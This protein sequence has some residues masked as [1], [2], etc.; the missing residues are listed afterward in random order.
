MKKRKGVK[1]KA[2]KMLL[3]LIYAGLIA[4]MNL[5]SAIIVYNKA[6]KIEDSQK[7]IKITLMSI[8]IRFFLFLAIFTVILLITTLNQKVF[9]IAFVTFSFLFIFIEIFYINIK[10]KCLNL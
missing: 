2:Q 4:S 10:A 9:A 1:T 6:F 3:E 5:I 7:F 8:I